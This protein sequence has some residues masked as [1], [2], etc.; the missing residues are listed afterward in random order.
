MEEIPSLICNKYFVH[1]FN[2][3]FLNFVVLYM[4]NDFYIKLFIHITMYRSD[5]NEQN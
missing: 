2:F 1:F 4:S 5:S 3:V